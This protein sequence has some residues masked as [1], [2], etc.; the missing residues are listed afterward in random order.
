[1]FKKLQLFF[2]P[3]DGDAGGG[4]GLSEGQ[5]DLADIEEET[6]PE[7]EQEE[8]AEG[9]EE[10]ETP[11]GEEG[12]EGEEEEEEDA[13]EEGQEEEEGAEGKPRK[14]GEIER[15]A[16]GRVTFKAI[17]TKY[18]GI[19]KDV[20]ELKAAFFQLPKYQEIFADPETAADAKSKADEYDV[21]ESTL[22]NQANPEFLIKTIG[23][24]AP[25]ALVKLMKAFPAAL[26]KG[27]YEEAYRALANPI[28]EDLLYHAQNYGNRTKDKNLFLAARHIANFLWANG[29]E[30]PDITKR[31]KAKEPSEAERQLHTE[32]QQ[33]QQER[34]SGAIQ[35][36][37]SECAS[38][39]NSI[40]A[41]KLDGLTP[42]EKRML[43]R[44]AKTE[45]DATLN[46]D[47]TLQNTLKSLWSK[48][49]ED[50]YSP[51][52]KERIKNAWLSR[53][54]AVAPGIRNRLKDEAI[55]GRRPG[56]EGDAGQRQ[57]KRTFSSQGGRA[58][59]SSSRVV[60]PSK[61]DWKKTS[62][63]DIL[64]DDT[65]RVHLKK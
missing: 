17:N 21:I 55:G 12:E 64:G 32:R 41:N 2:D 65:S 7:G 24:N 26:Q 28:V 16:D 33:H 59:R 51:A 60:D 1:M 35:S 38:S 18:P 20:P 53:A 57:R 39:V 31:E 5:Q 58:T 23:E 43:V 62:D 6:P 10:E 37:G 29:G 47:K 19:F 22:V 34:F 4:E 14:T 36:I 45:L 27:E 42:F 13:E 49:R 9:E 48:A 15:D 25:K 8:E 56:T 54:K 63:A 3:P 46:K 52:S 40:L 44:E 30:V 61:I 50:G 11:E